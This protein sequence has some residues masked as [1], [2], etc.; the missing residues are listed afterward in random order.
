[1]EHPILILA[2]RYPQL[3]L[4]ICNG[5]HETEEYK[6]AVLRGEPVNAVPDFSFSEGDSLTSVTTPAGEAE[7]LFLSQREDFEHFI[8]AIAYRCEDREIPR[9][10]GA[11]TL[12]GIVNWQ[13]LHSHMEAYKAAGGTDEDGEFAAFTADRDNY[14]DTIIVLSYG[15]Y[16][17]VSAEKMNMDEEEWRERSVTIRKY[18]ELTHFI[19]RRLFIENK[20]AVRDEVL[21]DMDGIIAAFGHYDTYAA[22]L[23]L[24]T[25]GETY[26]EGGRLQN[27]VDVAELPGLMARVNAMI[28]TLAEHVKDRDMADVFSLLCEIEKNKICIDY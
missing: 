14:R 2:E 1:M 18:H 7:V 3:K 26:R 22:K 23:F 10:M 6:S 28:D 5:M 21:A 25:E 11:S 9:S 20:D 17:A 24:G 8:R 13:K 12:S 15:G 27:Y 19:S 16:S 4:R